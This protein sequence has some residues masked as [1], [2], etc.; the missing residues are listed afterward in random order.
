MLDCAPFRREWTDDADSKFNQYKGNCADFLQEVRLNVA[1]NVEGFVPN[2]P[3]MHSGWA[4]AKSMSHFTWDNMSPP[5][6][7]MS[8]LGTP[9]EDFCPSNDGLVL[10][11][12]HHA[13]SSLQMPAMSTTTSLTPPMQPIAPAPLQQSM[14]TSSQRS[15]AINQFKFSTVSDTP[16]PSPSSNDEDCSATSPLSDKQSL[17]E[18]AEEMGLSKSKQEILK[19]IPKD[20]RVPQRKGNMQLWQFLYAILE[21]QTDIIEWTANKSEYEFRLLQPD[22][23][24][25]WWGHQ[26]NRQNMNYD[27]LSRSLRYYYNRKIITKVNSERYVYRFC[28]NPELLYS[29]LGNS[30]AKPKLKE[31]PVEAKQI[32]EWNQG[33]PGSRNSVSPS[34][35]LLRA[36]SP[37]QVSPVSYIYP[38][39][40]KASLPTTCAPTN[41]TIPVAHNYYG[42][43][44]QQLQTV[45]SSF[46]SQDYCYPPYSSSYPSVMPPAPCY[47]VYNPTSNIGADWDHYPFSI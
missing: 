47:P 11:I 12:S 6:S 25:I 19:L 33:L 4:P 41:T 36:P 21:D 35:Q 42:M 30:H 20:V 24:A 28:C 16:T 5:M 14:I 32:L 23:V 15:L 2:L 22:V 9:T 45:N 34:P 43:D 17:S 31:M 8:H 7:V 46:V 26:K 37:S 13:C 44:K 39:K 1:N 3:P 38:L 40:N 18:F 27:K 29:V 10:P